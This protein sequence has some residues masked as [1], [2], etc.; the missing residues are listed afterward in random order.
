MVSA[1]AT[2]RRLVLGQEAVPAKANELAAIPALL[3]RLAE[4]DGLKGA[5]V[6]V[7][8][9]ATNAAIAQA[10]RNA[11]A[12][13]LLAVKANQPTL[14]GEV[15]AAFAAAPP[16]A[17]RTDTAIDKGHGRIERRTV[18][19][20][21]EVGWLRGGERRFPGEFRLPGPACLIR[22]E[23]SSERGTGKA[24]G[25]VR[26]ETRYYISSANLSAAGA[27]RPSAAIGGSRTACIGCS[28][29]SS[30]TTSPASGRDTGPGT[31]PSSAT[32][33]STS[34]DPQT[35]A[36]PSSSTA[37]S[38]DGTRNTSMPCSTCNSMNLDSEP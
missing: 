27:A 17:L 30:A 3:A 4:G 26:A 2:T 23:A 13:Y 33:P 35:T 29:S 9:I 14:R 18:S 15:E 31:W 28:T 6:S 25:K 12:D 34:S 19:L 16:A 20:L 36:D 10:I 21:R 32:S 37:N 1:F 38:P 24:P 11:G 8:A 5:L 22:V 7:D